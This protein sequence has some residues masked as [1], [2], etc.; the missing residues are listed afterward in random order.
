VHLVC[1]WL[2]LVPAPLFISFVK[3]A[4]GIVKIIV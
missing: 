3:L 4:F 1:L 2:G